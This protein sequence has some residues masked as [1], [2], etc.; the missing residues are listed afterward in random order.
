MI[1]ANVAVLDSGIGGLSVLSVLTKKLSGKRFFYF[2]DNSN[3]PYGNK[4]LNELRRLCTNNLSYL[5]DFHFDAIV[6][7]CNTLSV[8]LLHEIEYFSGIKTF[9]VFPPAEYARITG[10]KTLLLSTVST[11]KNYQKSEEFFPLGLEYLAKDIENNI[12]AI[13]KIDLSLHFLPFLKEKN[14]YDT[15]ILG[16]THYEF[17]KNKIFNHLKPQKILSGINF[18]ADLV[19]EYFHDDKSLVKS[20]QNEIFF[21]GKNADYNRE[22]FYMVVNGVLKL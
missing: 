20:R 19:A 17:I 14:V 4:S 5:S 11:A 9:G 12:F 18:T 7:G 16:C 2:G 8:N 13:D 1:N 3:A 6:L 15:V 21:I 22:I 10:E